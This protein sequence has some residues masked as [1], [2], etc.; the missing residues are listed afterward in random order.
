[1]SGAVRAWGR[2]P[3]ARNRE[4][5]VRHVWMHVYVSVMLHGRAPTRPGTRLRFLEIEGRGCGI[6]RLRFLTPE[7][8]NT[9]PTVRGKCSCLSVRCSM[10]F[11]PHDAG[12]CTSGYLVKQGGQFKSW[13][14]RYFVLSGLRLR[15]FESRE[16]YDAGFA[17]PLGEITC[18]RVTSIGTGKT[19]ICDHHRARELI[20]R[21]EIGCAP[22]QRAHARSTHSHSALTTHSS[23]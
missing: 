23:D 15:W 4:A 21:S 19:C 22:Q 7:V 9:P 12:A 11:S 14:K 3:R 6:G 18:G 5:R 10:A 1:M 2:F 13:R 20:V 16:V 17:A 8:L